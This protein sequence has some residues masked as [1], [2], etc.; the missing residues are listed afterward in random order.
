MSLPPKKKKKKSPSF[1]SKAAGSSGIQQA[2]ERRRKQRRLKGA[3]AIHAN[4]SLWT[5]AG[6]GEQARWEVG[7]G[8]RVGRSRCDGLQQPANK[9]HSER[10]GPVFD[11]CPRQQD[12][13][14]FCW[15][16][17]TLEPVSLSVFTQVSVGS[18]TAPSPPSATS[19]S[20]RQNSLNRLA[21]L[22]Q[23]SFMQNFELLLFQGTR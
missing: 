15:V 3:A 16:C 5:N 12:I 21:V 23:P 20:I 19:L 4:R 9:M 17:T 22:S 14:C 8:R 10:T 2:R 1:Q 11:P 13:G 6:Q 7:G 18:L